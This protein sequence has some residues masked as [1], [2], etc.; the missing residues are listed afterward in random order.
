MQTI[1]N[2]LGASTPSFFKTL[3]NIGLVLTAVSGALLTAPVVLPAAVIT[4]AGYLAVSGSVVAVVSQLTTEPAVQAAVA[5]TVNQLIPEPVGQTVATVKDQLP[6][7]AEGQTPAVTVNQLAFEPVVD[8]PIAGPSG[9]AVAAAMVSQP[10]TE[11]AEQTTVAVKGEED[12]T[13]PEQ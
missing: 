4:I 7:A 6:T 12:E 5:T 3:R 2:R 13:T 8:Q 10:P 11:P 9:Q 1:I